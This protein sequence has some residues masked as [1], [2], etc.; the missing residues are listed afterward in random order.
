MPEQLSLGIGR[1]PGRTPGRISH[2]EDRTL[3]V[4]TTWMLRNQWIQDYQD[5]VIRYDVPALT[6][7]QL[8][9]ASA[10]LEAYRDRYLEWRRLMLKGGKAGYAA[11]DFYLKKGTPD[12]AER[13]WPPNDDF[14]V[15][16]WLMQSR[17]PVIMADGETWLAGEKGNSRE[18]LRIEVI[19]TEF[20]PQERQKMLDWMDG[21][22]SWDQQLIYRMCQMN[23]IGEETE[24]LIMEGDLSDKSRE[25]LLY[26]LRNMRLEAS[27]R[28]N[29]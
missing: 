17:I 2:F 12:F 6:P 8:R 28:E 26:N 10:S 7:E 16:K 4:S 22:K 27:K 23:D 11:G 3:F 9:E 25:N 15:N 14:R 21:W 1:G 18:I 19:N 5:R 24:R 13:W 20:F 29:P